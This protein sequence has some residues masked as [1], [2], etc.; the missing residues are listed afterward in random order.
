M[1]NPLNNK[2]FS[3]YV[4]KVTKNTFVNPKIHKIYGF[5]GIQTSKSCRNAGPAV[6]DS[7][8]P[9]S[10]VKSPN[11]RCFVAKSGL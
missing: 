7:G 3:N 1:I 5:R 11:I 10:I 4:T 2:K 9:S 6:L 8:G